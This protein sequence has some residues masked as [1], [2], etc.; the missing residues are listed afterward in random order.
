[1]K[2]KGVLNLKLLAAGVSIAAV[3]IGGYMLYSHGK[4]VE[5][6]DWELRTAKAQQE[7]NSLELALHAQLNTA[8]TEINKL[9]A[10]DVATIGDSDDTCAN[11][12]MPA[13][14]YNSLQ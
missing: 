6:A 9:L 1:M 3:V 12:D 13:D 5:R 7:H 8:E 14:I 10:K 4:S 11:T 2:P